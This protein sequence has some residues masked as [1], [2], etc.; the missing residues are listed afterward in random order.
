MASTTVREQSFQDLDQYTLVLKALFNQKQK[1]AFCDVILKVCG[2]EIY[3]HSSVLAASSPYFSSFLGQDSPRQFS[4]RSPQVIE[5]QIDGSEPNHRYEDAVSTVVEFIYT[6]KMRVNKESVDQICEIARIM[7]MENVVKFCEIFPNGDGSDVLITRATAETH[8]STSVGYDGGLTASQTIPVKP[9]RNSLLSTSKEAPTSN[10]SQ[11]P[12]DFESEQVTSASTEIADSNISTDSTG[13]HSGPPSSNNENMNEKE[14]S[15]KKSPTKIVGKR[16]RPPKSIKKEVTAKQRK[17]ICAAKEP[18]DHQDTETVES[19]EEILDSLVEDVISD[20]RPASLRR[21]K[22]VSKPTYKLQGAKKRK[23]APPVKGKVQPQVVS[24]NI[25]KIEPESPMKRRR[26]RPRK[27]DKVTKPEPQDDA[28]DGEADGDDHQEEDESADER[29]E[30]RDRRYGSRKP[31]IYKCKY[32]R[33]STCNKYRLTQHEMIHNGGK[34]SCSECGFLTSKVREMKK[35]KKEHLLEQ[36]ICTF[37]ERKV[38]TKEELDDHLLRHTGDAPYF[39]EICDAR[40]KT[41]TQLNLHLPKHSNQKPF[42]C[43]L[44]N[45]GFKW[46]HALKNHMIVHSSKKDHLCDVCGYAT[47]HKSQ[48][49]AH[50]LIHTGET[51]KCTIPDCR[52]QA[53]KRQNLKYHMLTHTG[54]KPHQCELCGQAFS[55]IKNMRR[56]MLLHTDERPHL[57]HH[58]EF[59]T[60]RYDKLKEHLLKQHNLGVPPEKRVKVSDLASNDDPLMSVQSPFSN[61]METT[62]VS[63]MPIVSQTEEDIKSPQ[64][65]VVTMPS[66]LQVRITRPDGQSQKAEIIHVT[67]AD[68]ASEGVVSAECA[69]VEVATANQIDYLQHVQYE[70]VLIP[71][72][73]VPSLVQQ[74][75]FVSQ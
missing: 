52:F 6:G 73:Q 58:C 75:T 9:K 55:L 18:E 34:M 44:C 33:Y 43:K 31:G 69:E 16:G 68:G 3:A 30:K 49:K 29:E 11:L 4:P 45:I 70:E 17:E 19:E 66:T 20:R 71:A 41:R 50:R 5:I 72:S 8:V 22:R 27:C 26:G 42:V 63:D 1:K 12:T 14:T 65:E 61:L 10:E 23:A 21:T 74:V 39:C 59:S 32:C 37:C 2:K 28:D 48:L 38:E 64:M 60:T 54:E 62:I 24:R 36:N 15:I 13:T 7:Q 56:H 53:T 51:F 67:P 57:C 25:S 40:Y 46:K 35:H 47:A